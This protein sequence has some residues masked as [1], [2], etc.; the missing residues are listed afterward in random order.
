[1][2]CAMRAGPGPNTARASWLRF[3]PILLLVG[4]GAFLAGTRFIVAPA[5]RLLH[6]ITGRAIPGIATDATWMDRAA[7]QGEEAPD[8]A[9]EL[10]GIS[11]GTS[12]AD[13][14]AGTGYL[15]IRLARLVGPRGHVCADGGHA[16]RRG[17]SGGWIHPD[18]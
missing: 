17:A 1:N 10:I 7:R 18:Q 3:L 6:P 4:I 9:L 13:V 8:R 15:A 5:P 16:G 11:P 2:C 14:G 12:V